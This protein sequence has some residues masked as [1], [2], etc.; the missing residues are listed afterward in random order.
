MHH[1]P[2]CNFHEWVLIFCSAPATSVDA[3]WAFSTGRHQVNFTQHNINSQTFS[4]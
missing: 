4:A 2:D 3:E 1:I